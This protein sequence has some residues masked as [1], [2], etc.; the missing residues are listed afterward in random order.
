M[1][2]CMV[3]NMAKSTGEATEEQKQRLPVAYPMQYWL[4]ANEAARLPKQ[5]LPQLTGPAWAALG[6]VTSKVV[7]CGNPERIPY[8]RRRTLCAE[9]RV[10]L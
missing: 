8:S 1:N 3:L 5:N 6:Q 4:Y 7:E 10:G 2:I 9:K